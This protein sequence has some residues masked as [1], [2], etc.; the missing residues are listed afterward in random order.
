[1]KLYYAIETPLRYYSLVPKVTEFGDLFIKGRLES[2][3]D[4][5]RWKEM[6]HE[7]LAN[8]PLSF[9]LTRSTSELGLSSLERSELSH[10][11]VEANRPSLEAMDMFIKRYGLLAAETSSDEDGNVYFRESAM[12]FWVCQNTLQEAWKGNAH[13][14]KNMRK[15]VQRKLKVTPIIEAEHV[16]FTTEQLWPFICMLFFRDYAAGIIAICKIPDCPRTPYFLRAREGQVYCS[17][18][19]AVLAN[20]RRFREFHS[21][22][23][24]R[25]P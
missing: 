6:P 1:M 20:V 18:E 2:E 15:Q 25:K 11:R 22:R 8:L 3:I 4:V 21:N 13:E 17:H 16:N 5:F 12:G 23:K 14:L 19:C 9:G 7:C 24:R 10:S